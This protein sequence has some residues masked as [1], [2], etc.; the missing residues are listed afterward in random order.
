VHPIL[1]SGAMVR[2]IL[3]G[4]KTMT[5]RVVKYSP[6]LGDPD[7]WCGRIGEPEFQRIVGDYRRFCPYGQPG[8]RLWVRETWAVHSLQMEGQGTGYMLQWRADGATRE[9]AWDGG[10]V[11]QSSETG[12][13]VLDCCRRQRDRGW[14]PSIHMP[15]WASRLTL[16]VTEIRVER[17]QAISEEDARAEGCSGRQQFLALWDSMET[18]DGIKSRRGCSWSDDPWVWVVSFGLTE[19]TVVT[20]HPPLICPDCQCVWPGLTTGAEATVTCA[21]GRVLGCTMRGR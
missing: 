19:G 8:D 9:A 12:D 1:F 16:A 6:M 2:A 5:R 10:R 4:R 11:S 18:T 15:R 7:Q 13:D 3:D 17:L 21:C 20:R 14:R